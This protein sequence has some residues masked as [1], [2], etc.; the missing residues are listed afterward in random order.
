MLLSDTHNLAEPAGAASLAGLIKEQ[1]E[2]A[3]KRIGV[4]LTGSNIDQRTLREI[5][6]WGES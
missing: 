6:S 2:M 4:I 3:G 5:I 1:R